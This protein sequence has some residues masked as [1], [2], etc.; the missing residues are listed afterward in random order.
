M[1]NNIIA[2]QHDHIFS[3]SD[4]T[5]PHDATL[6]IRTIY[7]WLY[8]PTHFVGHL[9]KTIIEIMDSQTIVKSVPCMIKAT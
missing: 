2:Y 3:Y 5:F 6:Y 7:T 8:V 9:D 4:I 1:Y